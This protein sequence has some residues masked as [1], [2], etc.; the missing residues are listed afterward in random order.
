M[1]SSP[2][3]SNAIAQVEAKEATYRYIHIKQ[4]YFASMYRDHSSSQSFSIFKAL[5]PDVP[6]YEVLGMLEALL[7]YAIDEC[8]ELVL[9][10]SCRY[11]AVGC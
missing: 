3:C 2:T 5:V 6:R 10:L 11:W 1:S 7:P 4:R 8:Q 9:Y